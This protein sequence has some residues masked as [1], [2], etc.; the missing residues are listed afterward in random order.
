MSTYDPKQ[1]LFDYAS[2]KLTP[3]MAAGHSLQHIDKLYDALKATRHEWRTQNEALD[4][5]INALQ[6][7]VDRLTAFMD[8]VKRSQKLRPVPSQPNPDQT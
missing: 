8:K 1:V 3:E 7:A 5:R 2:G 4:K 6:V